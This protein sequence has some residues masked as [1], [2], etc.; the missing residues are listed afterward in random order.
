MLIRSMRAVP[1]LAALVL[2]VACGSDGLAPAM[3]SDAASVTVSTLP[4][5]NVGVGA[6]AGTFTVKVSNPSGAGVPGVLVKFN[7]TGALVAAPASA[8]TD[9]AGMASTQITAGT[10]AG[11]GI[12][13]AVA[14]GVT[15]AGSASI[16]IIPGTTT[17]IAVS[18]KTIRFDAVGDTARISAV[19]QDQYG[20]VAAAA[21]VTYASLDPSLVSVDAAGLARAIRLNGSTRIVASSN[22]KSDTTVVTVLAA[23]ASACTGFASTTPMLVGEIRTLSTAQY[24]CVSSGAAAGEFALVAFNSSTDQYGALSVSVTGDGLAVPPANALIT[25]NAARAIT[26]ASG[27]A[28]PAPQRNEQFH[29]DLLERANRQF[30]GGLA[31]LHAA[32]QLTPSRSVIGS[33]A[34]VTA[35]SVIPVAAKVGDLITLNVSS[36]I[37]TSPIYHGLRVVAIGSKSIVLAD[38]LNPA[39]GFASADYSRIAANFDTLVYA[40]DVGA[41][42]APSDIDGN[43]KVAILF[44]RTV[45]ELVDS[46]SGYYVGGFFNPR[47]LFPKKGATTSDDCAGS[48]EGEMFYMLVPAPSPGINGVTHTAGFVD[49]LTTGI[50]AHEFQHLINAGRRIYVNTGAT[51]FEESWLNEGLSHIAEELL[52]YRE[53]KLSPRQ[54]LDDA[55]I[56]TNNPSI[57]PFW[58]ND[59]SSNFSRFLTYLRAP[60]T[61]SPYGPDD[62]L[63][64]RG[65]SWAFLRYAADRLATTDGTI[66]Q[67]FDNATTT[68][69]ATL[70]WVFG[71]DP[72]ALFRDFAVATYADD[73]GSTDPRFVNASWNFRSIFTTTFLGLSSYPLK[74][75]S[76]IDKTKTNVSVRG[77]SAAYL[78]FSSAA[79]KEALINLSSGGAAPI[80]PLLFTVMRTK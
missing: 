19:I 5:A 54:N 74:T 69:L 43:G 67:R 42:G 68:G 57:Y 39:G 61:N 66:W 1:M 28:T 80:S 76:L 20:N 79:G 77:L 14:T 46:N 24:Q 17:A 30:K 44:T 78:R 45:N 75:T 52:Y 55:A 36:S 40:L 34:G 56:R 12:V 38:T 47:D 63:A 2:A 21:A 72:L 50:V 9:A 26:S 49:S 7:T 22:G 16:T 32:L 62:Q 23:G 3:S 70:Q 8:T 37:C 58:K 41:F 73:L 15:T 13:S 60:E 51:A 29:V 11:S 4:S 71:Q 35:A 10:I 6:S 48:N 65:A 64:T 33:N 18:P 31:R 59:A 27:T 53:S 25:P